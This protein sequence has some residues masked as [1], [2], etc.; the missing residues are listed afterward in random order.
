MQLQT[1]QSANARS[2]DLRE[3]QLPS[4]NAESSAANFC[5]NEIEMKRLAM[6]ELTKIPTKVLEKRLHGLGDRVVRHLSPERMNSPLVGSNASKHVSEQK[7]WGQVSPPTTPMSGIPQ[8]TKRHNAISRLEP[9]LELNH[10][11]NKSWLG[12]STATCAAAMMAIIFCGRIKNVFLPTC[13]RRL[14]AV[15]TIQRA[16]LLYFYRRFYGSKSRRAAFFVL[17]K[18]LRKCVWRWRNRKRI[19]C[20][21]FIR[22]FLVS[23]KLRAK[24]ALAVQKKVKMVSHSLFG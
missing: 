24:F 8:S 5:L 7:H 17:V 22:Q 18:R 2:P 20:I 16:Y 13:D 12:G 9:S 10:V 4:R 11:S 14:Q 19:K 21:H 23:I 15:N 3:K 1:I 6:S